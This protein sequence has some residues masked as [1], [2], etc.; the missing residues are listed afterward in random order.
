MNNQLN[1]NKWFQNAI[2]KKKFEAL[3]FLINQNKNLAISLENKKINEHIQNKSTSITLKGLYQQ[4]KSS[5]Y[6]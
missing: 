4:K 6:L 3:E 5:I 2:F 1:Y